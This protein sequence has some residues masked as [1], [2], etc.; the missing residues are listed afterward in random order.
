MKIEKL[1]LGLFASFLMVGCS[2]NDDLPNGEENAKGKDSYISIKINSGMT[3]SRSSGGFEEGQGKE[4]TVNH[5]QFFFFDA[6]GN[7]FNVPVPTTTTAQGGQTVVENIVAS[8]SKD[9]YIMARGLNETLSNGNVEK[10]LDAIVVFKVQNNSYPSS[11]IAVLNW[12]YTGP[13]LNK[14][15]LMN[16]LIAENIA[17][18][19]T[20]TQN[21]KGF[22]MCNTVYK[23]EDYQTLFDATPVTTAN[24]AESPNAA[25]NNA[26]EIYVERLAAKVNVTIN[27][28]NTEITDIFE[29]E[30]APDID[31]NASTKIYAK[32]L[33][34]DINT[35][36]TYSYLG[37]HLDNSWNAD[38]PFANWNHYDPTNKIFRS[39]YAEAVPSDV[40]TEDED[41]EGNPV[42]TSIK[43]SFTWSSI[44]NTFGDDLQNADYCLE[45]TDETKY[46]KVLVKAQLGTLSDAGAFT[47]QT[48]YQWYSS[49]YTSLD[50]LRKAVAQRVSE[51]INGIT[52]SNISVTS[53]FNS[54]A[55]NAHDAYKV[56]FGVPS[57]GTYY[58]PNDAT[59]PLTEA[60]ITE[61]FNNVSDAKVWTDGA[62][63]YFTKILHHDD[64][65]NTKDKY[66][67][68]RNHA[69]K[70]S[71]EGVKGLGT[72]VYVPTT[73]IPGEEPIIPDPVLPEE[74]DTYI[75]AQIN[76]LS[77]KLVNNNVVLGQ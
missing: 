14:Q 77:W 30:A 22:I 2:Q 61:I 52:Y 48:I 39:Y 28:S 46:T 16:K 20:V 59:T 74:K 35:T 43:S 44:P 50:E 34:W 4:N 56:K 3:G 67:V 40:T 65:D 66:A 51:Y 18:T 70:V 8:G 62:T 33:K 69:Y 47:A 1:M 71:I 32:L 21:Q 57:N 72:P 60:Q 49:Y 13:G 24:F 9:N 11:V 41:D 10:F 15:Q 76:V 64:S 63:Y 68:I 75:A 37:K 26:I 29:V 58:S 55:P 73:E 31:K 6:N 45:N 36:S 53:K 38:T 23:S 42:N 19:E 25:K 5:V 7:A 54:S 27:Q 12:N 17:I